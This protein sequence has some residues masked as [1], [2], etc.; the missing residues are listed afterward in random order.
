MSEQTAVTITDMI[1]QAQA[2][3]LRAGEWIDYHEHSGSSQEV[4]DHFKERKDVFEATMHFL[5]AVEPHLVA[6]RNIIKRGS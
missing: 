1:D 3:A 4:I 5:I 2:E 6:V